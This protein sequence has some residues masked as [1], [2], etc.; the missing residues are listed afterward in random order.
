MAD[1]K[2]CVHALSTFKIDIRGVLHIGAHVCEEKNAYNEMGISDSNIIWIDGNP[3]LI[4]NLKAQGATNVYHALIDETER[5]VTF[6]IAN[7]IQS[8]SILDFGTHAIHHPNVFYNGEFELMTTTIEKFINTN[9]IDIKNFNF[10]TLDIQGVELQALKG[11]NEY[12]KF[13]DGLLVEVTYEEL[14]KGGAKLHQLDA[15]LL[16]KGF[17][18][19][20]T[21]INH[22]YSWG[23]AL[24][25]RYPYFT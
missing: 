5:P 9:N 6:N 12:L 4:E 8:S 18:R 23:D 22:P 21:Y 17:L 7:N 19:L 10:W 13:A 20:D 24:Y 11:A 14:Y 16:E 15:F 3:L 2:R 25:V 1:F